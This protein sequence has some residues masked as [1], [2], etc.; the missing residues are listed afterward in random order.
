MGEEEE[1][2]ERLKVERNVERRELKEYLLVV[3]VYL[4]SLLPALVVKAAER[5]GLLTDII[6]QVRI[7][8]AF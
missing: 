3:I 5:N 6:P 4:C 2:E 1:E 7:R 8:V